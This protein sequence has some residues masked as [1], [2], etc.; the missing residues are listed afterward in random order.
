L[1]EADKTMAELQ[2]GKK[3]SEQEISDITIFLN[4]LS[5]IRSV[6]NVSMKA[7]SNSF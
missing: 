1:E 3:L 6:T 4:S 7:S 5:D 2:L